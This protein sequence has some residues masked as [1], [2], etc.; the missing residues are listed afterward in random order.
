MNGANPF[1]SLVTDQQNTVM[2][3]YTALFEHFKIMHRTL[4]FINAYDFSVQSV[5]Y[6]QILHSVSLFLA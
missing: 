3:V 6:D 2:Y 5:N 4:G 1:E